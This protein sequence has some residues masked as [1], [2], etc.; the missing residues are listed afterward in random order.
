VALYQAARKAADDAVADIGIEKMREAAASGHEICIE[1]ELTSG[2]FDLTRED[3]TLFG[4]MAR[5]AIAEAIEGR[6]H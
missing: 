5:H 2:H 4:W 6:P 3:R 1:G